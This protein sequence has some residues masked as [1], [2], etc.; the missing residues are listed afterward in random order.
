MQIGSL[1]SPRRCPVQRR[2][3]GLDRAID[4][5]HGVP[6]ENVCDPGG[7]RMATR[8]QLLTA[9][10]VATGGVL[11]AGGT[12]AAIASAGTAAPAADPRD[13]V[14]KILARIKPPTF[15]AKEFVITNFGAKGDGKTDNTAA[16]AK[17]IKAASTAGGGR[18]T[19]PGG[20]VLTRA[21]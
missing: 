18:A 16:F 20:K 7:N 12:G 5:C 8:R 15:P 14:P 17:A 2:G 13:E 4:A 3:T 9:T 11:L 19:V 21:I 6:T 1:K 10:G